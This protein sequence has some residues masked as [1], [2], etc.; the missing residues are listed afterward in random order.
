MHFLHQRK[1][2]LVISIVS[3]MFFIVLASLLYLGFGPAF[4]LN[5]FVY[6]LIISSQLAE[7]SIFWR[8]I[9]TFGS[10][11][12]LATLTIFT[13]LFFLLKRNSIDALIYVLGMSFGTAIVAFVKYLTAIERP[14]YVYAIE[15]T[16]SFPSGHT[17]LSVIFLVVTGYLYASNKSSQ[18][19]KLVIVAVIAS[20]LMIAISRLMLGEHWL[21]DIVGG[22]LLGL[23]ISSGII[24]FF[25]R[26]VPVDEAG[27]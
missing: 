14:D 23:S 8:I 27:V 16:F 15:Q 10:V 7:L 26:R 5:T 20:S 25:T 1:T 3:A 24:L 6:N 19:K 22:Y 2:Y 12:F 18:H 11:V 13:T 9:T 17:T 21:L 4:K